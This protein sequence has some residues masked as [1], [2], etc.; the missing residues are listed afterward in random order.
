MG[1]QVLTHICDDRDMKMR[2]RANCPLCRNTVHQGK[3]ALRF[4][5]G[6]AHPE[7][8]VAWRR[9]RMTQRD[10]NPA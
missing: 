7:C 1:G 6:Y 5:G 2:F 4:F 10:H 8:A 3:N 9:R